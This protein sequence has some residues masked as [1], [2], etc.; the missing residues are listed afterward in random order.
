MN[1]LSGI[2]ATIWLA[3]YGEWRLILFGLVLVFGLRS[4][5]SLLLFP[6][7][8]I[9]PL[10]LYLDKKKNPLRY[11]FGYLMNVYINALVFGTCAFAFILCVGFY[12]GK[13]KIALIPY[14][15]WSWGIALA[16]WQQFLADEQNNE[17]TILTCFAASVLYF[18]FLVSTFVSPFMSLT[19]LIIAVLICVIFMPIGLNILAAWEEK[20]RS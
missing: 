1:M 3:I 17:F 18:L 13:S 12:D 5:M 2:I 9:L 10:M 16:P 4:F 15:L 20:Q 19:V 6:R 14:L 11:F 7:L 8:I